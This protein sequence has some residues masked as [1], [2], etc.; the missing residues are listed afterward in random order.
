ML[1]MVW[2][3]LSTICP[4]DQDPCKH[5]AERKEYHDQNCQKQ[6]G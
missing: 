5:V 3:R 4:L 2:K 6:H 1:L